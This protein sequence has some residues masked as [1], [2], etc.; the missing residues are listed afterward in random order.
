MT[1]LER[2]LNEAIQAV[3]AKYTT[4]DC[5]PCEFHGELAGIIQH[6]GMPETATGWRFPIGNGKPKGWK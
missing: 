4:A 3:L 2:E 6:K 5:G 1:R